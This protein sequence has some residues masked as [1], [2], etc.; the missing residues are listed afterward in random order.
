MG[1]MMLFGLTPN[2]QAMIKAKCIGHTIFDVIDRVPEI[3]DHDGCINKFEIKKSISFKNITF[4][5]PTAPEKVK[6]VL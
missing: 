3:R 4:R 6:N 1:M 2:M 5:Y